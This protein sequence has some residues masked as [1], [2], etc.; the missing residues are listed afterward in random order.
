MHRLQKDSG[1]ESH[2]QVFG[3]FVQN[4]LKQLILLKKQYQKEWS[5]FQ[6]SRFFL[7]IH[8][9]TLQLSLGKT[10]RSAGWLCLP[11]WWERGQC[12][13]SFGGFSLRDIL[14][15]TLSCAWGETMAFRFRQS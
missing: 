9:L 12:E 7:W 3:G 5:C 4:L 1:K 14:P 13:L 6:G 11:L 2:S 15:I 8:D 10:G